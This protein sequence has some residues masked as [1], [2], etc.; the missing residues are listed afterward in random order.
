[1]AAAMSEGLAQLKMMPGEGVS[2]AVNPKG[3]ELARDK[4]ESSS[5]TVRNISE[6]NAQNH[7]A[8]Y[9]LK[10]LAA[11]HHDIG[12]ENLHFHFLRQPGVQ[13]CQGGFG[14]DHDRAAVRVGH[15]HQ[16]RGAVRPHC[17]QE[18]PETDRNATEALTVKPPAC[19]KGGVIPGTAGDTWAL[20]SGHVGPGLRAGSLSMR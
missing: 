10:S 15:L 7:G 16:E 14:E 18:A 19:G 1:M 5:I 4:G 11:C 17:P 12:P 20:K 13:I 2:P 9:L 8:T 3:S 6:R